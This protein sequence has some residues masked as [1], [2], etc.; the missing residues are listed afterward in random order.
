LVTL[1]FVTPSLACDLD[2]ETQAQVDEEE[3]LVIEEEAAPT[4]E[5]CRSW[6]E[7]KHH[8]DYEMHGCLGHE[9]RD[10]ERALETSSQGPRDLQPRRF[11]PHPR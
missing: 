11:S 4:M 8:I 6:V 7:S 10:A 9:V 2:V 5:E 1:L 3:D